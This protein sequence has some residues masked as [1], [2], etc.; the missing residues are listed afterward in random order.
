[1]KTVTLDLPG[2]V[3]FRVQKH[4]ESRGLTLSEQVSE[5]LDASTRDDSET[6]RASAI[7]RMNELFSQVRGFQVEPFIFREDLYERGHLR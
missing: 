1:M 4:A 7:E 3:V 2:Q 6:V 5:L